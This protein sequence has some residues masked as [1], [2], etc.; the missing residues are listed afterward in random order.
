MI[1]GHAGQGPA[2]QGNKQVCRPQFKLLLQVYGI[3]HINKQST[4]KQ[5][6][7]SPSQ[8]RRLQRWIPHFFISWHFDWHKNSSEHLHWVC[9]WPQRHAFSTITW[10]GGQGG[11]WQR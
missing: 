4:S 3:I 6:A 10:Q 8:Q 5:G 7:W 11:V 9:R 1:T 2:W